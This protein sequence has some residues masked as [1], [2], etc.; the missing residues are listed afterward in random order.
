VLTSFD[1]CQNNKERP[2]ANVK[3]PLVHQHRC[4]SQRGGQDQAQCP[5][6]LGFPTKKQQGDITNRQ[7]NKPNSDNIKNTHSRLASLN[8][9]PISSIAF[10]WLEEG[11]SQHGKLSLAS[12]HCDAAVMALPQQLPLWPRAPA[13]V[14]P[15]AQRIERLAQCCTAHGL[16]NGY[17]H[18]SFSLERIFYAAF[19]GLWDSCPGSR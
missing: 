8:D 9:H 10:A 6:D 7:D 5:I 17:R 19:L 16:V 11:P 4:D 15:L 12:E 2:E 1:I 13:D 14:L 3:V 18:K